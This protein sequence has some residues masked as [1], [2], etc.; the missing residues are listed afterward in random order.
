MVIRRGEIY[1]VDF[2]GARG[3][4]IRKTRP[5][6]VVSN[7]AHNFHM[8]TVTVVPLSS[9]LVKFRPHEALIPKGV[10]GDGRACRAVTHQIASVDRGR[11][12]RLLG[13][14]P[15]VLMAR[16]DETLRGHLGLD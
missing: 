2:G 6:V 10:V 1:W 5:A 14:L 12:G 13:E 9:A 8:S 11:V 4:E 15:S 16:V 7:D 3:A